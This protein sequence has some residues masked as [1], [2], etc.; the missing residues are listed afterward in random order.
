M[1]HD[2]AETPTL[3]SVDTVAGLA[4]LLRMLHVRAGKPPYRRLEKMLGSLPAERRRDLSWSK[5]T[6]GE[7]LS[8]K[9]LPT[10]SFVTGFVEVCLI[11]GAAEPEV[12]EGEAR[13]VRSETAAARASA[14]REVAALRASA[15]RE[16][17]L[18][19]AA[20]S[21]ELE[22]RRAEALRS[23]AEAREAD[24]REL[25]QEIAAER[26]RAA[27]DLA[28]LRD[29]A[30]READGL[31]A[32]ARHQLAQAEEAAQR[33]LREAAQ[34][35]QLIREP[36]PPRQTEASRAASPPTRRIIY[37]DV[38]IPDFLRNSF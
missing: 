12:A 22:S 27:A 2:G 28:E 9:R 36:A 18:H 24:L 34:T 14:E 20:A 17:A 3:D 13:R 7:V 30:R 6:I 31:L 38:D 1:D 35:A 10:R 21:R 8:G 37:E 11:T 33:I 23:V 25:R 29:Q 5:S 15:E 32:E 4:Q 16:I 19:R 26:E